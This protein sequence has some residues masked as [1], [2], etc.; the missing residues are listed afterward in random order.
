MKPDNQREHNA[1]QKQIKYK[2]LNIEYRKFHS[3]DAS[4]L[5]VQLNPNLELPNAL[6]IKMLKTLKK[7]IFIL[8]ILLPF[9]SLGFGATDIRFILSRLY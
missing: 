3:Q 4:Y 5:R 1:A 8:F 6:N 7:L 9:V 2:K